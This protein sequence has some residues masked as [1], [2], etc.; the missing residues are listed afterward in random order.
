MKINC[1]IT[2][3]FVLILI[4]GNLFAQQDLQTMMRER[5]EYFF[6]LNAKQDSEI[7]FINSICSVA[8]IENENI[9]CYANQ[10]QYDNLLK[11]GYQPNLLLPPSMQNEVKMWNGRGTYDWDTYPTYGQYA[12][13]MQNFATEHPDRCTYFELGTLQSG[14]KLMFCRINNGQPE[15]KPKF[16]YT[17][18]I[19]GDEVTGMMLMLRFLDE[20][21]TS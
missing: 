12:S 4:S 11:L 6:S 17:S 14:H 8:K 18:T 1:L 7:Q 20:L 21:C 9:I 3:L 10:K 19:H 16:L 15:G 13:M 5:G 2:Q